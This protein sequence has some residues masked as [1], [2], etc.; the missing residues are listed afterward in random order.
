MVEKFI[1]DAVVGVFGVP[2]AHEDDPERAVRAG[3]RIVE[4]AEELVTVGGAPLRL[5][6]GVNTGEALVRLGANPGVGERVLAGDAI[7][8]AS[9]LQSVAPEMGVVVGIS[10]FEATRVV[11]DYE[12][13]EPARLKGKAEPV[14]VFHARSP[15]ARFGT[16]LTRTH[17]SP[18]VGREIDLAL[19]KGV[20]DKSVAASSAQLVTVVGE[21]GLGKSRLVAELFG[22]ID[23]RPELV[24]WRQGRCLPYGEGITFWALGEIL[25]AHTGILESDPPAVARE[26]LDAVLPEGAEREWFKQ[27][28][29]PLLGIEATSSA[30]REELFTAWR[31]FLEGVAEADPTVLVFEDL[32]WAD[33]AMLAFLE[34]LADLAEGVPLLIVGTARP[35]LYERHPDYAAGMRNVEHDQPGAVDR[36]GDGPPRLGVAGRGGDPGGVAAADPRACRWQPPVCGGVRAALAGPGPA[37][38]SGARVGSC[39]PGVEMPFPDSVQALIAARLDTLEPDAKSLLADAAVIG[40]VFW[41]G[42]VAAMGDRDPQTVTLMLRELSRK[43]LVRPSRQSSMDGRGGVRVLACARP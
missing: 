30:E 20:F 35:E 43:E 12:E 7:N 24:T 36:R 17:D 22:Y 34:Q 23:S 5:R 31:R 28:L 16:D 3:L 15:R 8:T 14:R 38:A 40:K 32:H 29:L 1:G 9:R 42:A 4:G 41:A 27:R 37:G 2:A 39:K 25:K 21:P 33:E 10:T 18:F 6:V 26:K 19:L 13:L 11:F